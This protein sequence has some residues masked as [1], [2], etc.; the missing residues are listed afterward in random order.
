MSEAAE[1]TRALF[2]RELDLDLTPRGVHYREPA[3]GV[4]EGEWLGAFAQPAVV[5]NKVTAVSLRFA[6]TSGN[7]IDEYGKAML[8][9]RRFGERV[10]MTKSYE[11]KDQGGQFVYVG[12][13]HAGT[14]AGYWY[15]PLQPSFCGLFWFSRVDQLADATAEKLNARVRANSPR[16]VVAKAMTFVVITGSIVTAAISP[17]VSAG[18]VG[19]G[20]VGMLTLRHR[21]RALRREVDSWVAALG[22]ARK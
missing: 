5:V 14:L 7:S 6:S 9:I 13:L 12:E 15:S 18:L 16:L 2:A 4:F 11:N 22:A 17:V 1:R 21:T 8:S 19:V 10:Q 20:A 3:A